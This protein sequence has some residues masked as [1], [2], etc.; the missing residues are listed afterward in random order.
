MASSP[1]RPN[2]ESHKFPV[3]EHIF[4]DLTL[5][6]K[7][8]IGRDHSFGLGHVKTAYISLNIPRPASSSNII[9]DLIRKNRGI[10]RRLPNSIIQLGYDLR[11]KT[12][13]VGDGDNYA[14]EFVY[15]GV[16]NTLHDWFTW[17]QEPNQVLSVEQPGVLRKIA[18]FL[19]RDEAS[20]FSV[21]D[22]CDVLSKAIYGNCTTVFR[23]QCPVK[24]QPNEIDGMY[25]SDSGGRSTLYPIEAKALSTA[26]DLYLPQIHGAHRL[27]EQAYQDALVIPLG[28]QMT[29]D[30]M[31]IAVFEPTDDERLLLLGHEILSNVVD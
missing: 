12:G 13:P 5:H 16:G 23:V 19:R 9:I 17:P 14:G 31:R 22:Y 10:E 3:L 21:I 6:G 20:L 4:N 1:T 28:I 11:H 7:K 2:R 18:R 24:W 30:G 27:V 25:F 29:R 8:G 15:V 26:D